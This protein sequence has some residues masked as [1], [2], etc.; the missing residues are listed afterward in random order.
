MSF[1]CRIFFTYA[2][3]Y[4]FG[5]IYQLNFWLNLTEGDFDGNSDFDHL[6]YSAE[7]YAGT[8]KS[9]CDQSLMVTTWWGAL[10]QQSAM[11]KAS[12]C[13]SKSTDYSD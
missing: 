3:G 7:A 12:L 9:R 10:K 1:Q 6:M 13:T 11:D 4:L 2:I 5:C 8:L